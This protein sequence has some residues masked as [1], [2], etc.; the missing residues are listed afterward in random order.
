MN[1]LSHFIYCYV[2]HYCS[3]LSSF[4]SE[5]DD[6]GVSIFSSSW[7]YTFY[8]NNIFSNCLWYFIVLNNYSIFPRVYDLFLFFFQPKITFKC[9]FCIL[10]IDFLHFRYVCMFVIVY[11][12]VSLLDFDLL[13]TFVVLH[14]YLPVPSY[15][16]HQT[17]YCVF[18]LILLWS[19]SLF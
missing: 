19:F 17:I 1:L 5:I 15:N 14:L 4:H 8:L 18:K 7:K 6:S 11:I 3:V 10:C 2:L 16:H 9:S 13:D 12:Y